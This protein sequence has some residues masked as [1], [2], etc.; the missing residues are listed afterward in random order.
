MKFNISKLSDILYG[1]FKFHY[2]VTRIMGTLHGEVVIFCR[3]LLRMTDISDK[4]LHK[5]KT[6]L[7]LYNFFLK[8]L[9]TRQFAKVR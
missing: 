2:N 6:R 9:V 8:I 3:I 4:I 7:M 5:N 1:E